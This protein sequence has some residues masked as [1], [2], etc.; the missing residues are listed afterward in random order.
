[1]QVVKSQEEIQLDTFT[2]DTQV[3]AIWAIQGCHITM[4]ILQRL[5]VAWMLVKTGPALK[6][7]VFM[8]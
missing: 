4:S 3:K 1:M 8:P 2:G 6:N 7:K 5:D